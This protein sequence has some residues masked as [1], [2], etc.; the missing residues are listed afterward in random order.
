MDDKEAKDIVRWL[1]RVEYPSKAPTHREDLFA[2]LLRIGISKKRILNSKPTL[3]T[4]KTIEELYKL[5]K[6]EEK[7]Y[8]IKAIITLRLCMELFVGEEYSFFVPELKRR[9]NLEP[10]DS[11]FYSQH[12]EHDRKQK[13]IREGGYSHSDRFSKILISLVDSP[14]KL[15]IAQKFILSCYKVKSGFYNQFSKK[16]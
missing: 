1:I 4:R 5:L 16:L 8:D 11:V 2:D 9:Y 3:K 13:P 15:V 6:Y 14:Q 10:K 7:D 12:L